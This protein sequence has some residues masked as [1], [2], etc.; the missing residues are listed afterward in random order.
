MVLYLITERVRSLNL[1]VMVEAI[2]ALVVACI[3]VVVIVKRSKKKKVKKS[4][5]T[6]YGK[7]GGSGRNDGELSL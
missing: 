3:I 6:V 2:V 1:K 4:S 5:R 7:P